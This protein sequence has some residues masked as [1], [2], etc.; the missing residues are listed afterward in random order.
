[1]VTMYNQSRCPSVLPVC[2]V[3]LARCPIRPLSPSITWTGLL[4]KVGGKDDQSTGQYRASL[5]AY[6]S[7]TSRDKQVLSVTLSRC[8]M[9]CPS[10][11]PPSMLAPPCYLYLR[12]LCLPRTS[13]S[14]LLLLLL[15]LSLPTLFPLR[16]Q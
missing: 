9:A 12:G 6:S 2:F 14:L 10:N 5:A 7:A 4:P 15:L 13:L 8:M 16:T 11:R 3:G 1:M